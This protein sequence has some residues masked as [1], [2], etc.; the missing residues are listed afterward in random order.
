MP[1]FLYLACL[2]FAR[3]H[4]KFAKMIVE[5][6]EE[7]DRKGVSHMPYERRET[8]D[9]SWSNSRKELFDNC[10]RAY[11]YRYY[12]AH[13]GWES[14]APQEA[15]QA[16]LLKN[17]TSIPLAFAK[18]VKKAVGAFMGAYQRRAAGDP[19]RELTEKDFVG[20]V[21]GS[22]H[23]ACIRAAN[24]EGWRAHPKQNPMMLEKLNYRAGFSAPPVVAEIE[25][26]KG[27]FDLVAKNFFDSPTAAEVREGAEIIENYEDFCSGSFLLGSEAIKVWGKADTV[28]KK[29]G[30][31]IATL[32]RTGSQPKDEESDRLHAEVIIIYLCKR[33]RIK[34]PNAIVR[35]CELSS[36]KTKS[37]VLHDKDEYEKALLKIKASVGEMAEF[38]EGGDMANNKA[39]PKEKFPQKEN[40]AECRTCP[41]CLMCAAD[42]KAARKA[43]EGAG[44][45]A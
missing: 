10:K 25:K 3:S 32:W 9:F 42:A 1:A 29:D 16:Y 31:Y 13:N 41:F 6:T 18:G 40:H 36:G 22:L 38:L 7:A 30:K 20:I 19:A 39:L 34:A 24:Q 5:E 33:Y 37:Y 44:K 8:P 27:Q 26:T 28:H 45:A 15:R 43:Q 11:Y 23:D 2:R 35:I 4:A 14:D 12:C 21:K 17:T